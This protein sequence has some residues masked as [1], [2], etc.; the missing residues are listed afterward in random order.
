MDLRS[1]KIAVFGALV[2]GEPRT[3]ADEVRRRRISADLF[4]LPF[5]L[6]PFP[7]TFL[8]NLPMKRGGGGN[9]TRE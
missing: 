5:S 7:G 1:A 8:A 2:E 4:E 9:R 3:L 6:G